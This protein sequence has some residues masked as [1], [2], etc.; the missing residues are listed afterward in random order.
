MIEFDIT[1]HFGYLSFQADDV[2][3]HISK[4][5]PGDYT[6]NIDQFT[7]EIPKEREFKPFGEKL[8]QYSVSKGRKYEFLLFFLSLLFLE[9]CSQLVKTKIE[10][11]RILPATAGQY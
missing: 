4:T 9:I 1:Y 5:I 10:I 11:F 6:T 3:R 8:H 2:E 7:K